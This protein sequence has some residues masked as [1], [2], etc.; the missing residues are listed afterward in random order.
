M[1]QGNYRKRI[2]VTKYNNPLDCKGNV[3]LTGPAGTGK[4]YAI[5]DYIKTHP[6]TLLC[7]STG[8]AAVNIGGSTA[9]RLFSIPVPA[10]GA[11]P[12]KVPPSQLKVFAE[13]DAVIIDEI[14]MLR[15]DAFS[16]AARVLHRAE[17]LFGKKIRLIV[18]GDFSQLPPIVKKTEERFFTRYGFNKSGFCFTTKEWQDYKF[19]VVE[20]GEIKRQNDREFIK[21]L[22]RLRTGSQSSLPYFNKHVSKVFPDDAVHLCGTN[23][24][25]EKINQDYL[26]KIDAPL[27]AYQAVKKGI[28]GKELPCDEIVLIKKGCR[29]MFTAN[30]TILDADGNLNTEFGDRQG[31]G[32]YTNGM[33]GTVKETGNDYVDVETESGKLVHV[34]KH[35]WSIYKYAVDRQSMALKKTEIGSVQQIPLK[36]AK[37]VTIHKSQGKTFDR[38]VIRP[39]IFAAGQLYVA[40]SR[41]TSSE[42]LYLTEPVTEEAIKTDPV[43]KKFYEAGYKYDVPEGIIKKQ[44]EIEKKQSAKK[45]KSIKKT[46]KKKSTGST[47]KT[48]TKK[49]TAKASA[50]KTTGTKSKKVPVQKKV[51]AKG[52]KKREGKRT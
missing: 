48:K 7:A 25:A 3:F 44:K 16:F 1:G 20:L 24:E 28:T 26:D 39:N 15:N 31:T 42:G 6:N 8:T 50:K 27:S 49:K 46:T 19:K 34:E 36:V 22:Y 29:V 33:T 4:T 11:D 51:R 52:N 38:A 41:L 21:E 14:S 18:S 13:A 12:G 37:A 32:R 10:Y 9:H 35:K 45:K 30:D 5:N 43:V 23:Q 40:L 2:I 47:S 17:K